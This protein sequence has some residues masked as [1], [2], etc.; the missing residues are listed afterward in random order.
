LIGIGFLLSGGGR[1]RWRLWAV[2][3]VGGSIGNEM[4]RRLSWEG[5]RG[6]GQGQTVSMVR[7]PNS[8]SRLSPSLSVPPRLLATEKATV[9]VLGRTIQLHSRLHVQRSILAALLLLAAYFAPTSHVP[10]SSSSSLPSTASV[11]SPTINQLVSQSEELLERLRCLSI[12][13]M[14]ILHHDEY[15]SRVRSLSFYNRGSRAVC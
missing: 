4:W 7:S 10:A 6:I 15:R 12:E 14:S 8:L 9:F 2:F 13:R 3:A 11:I 1:E 5:L